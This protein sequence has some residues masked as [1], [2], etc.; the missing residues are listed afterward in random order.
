MKKP[1]LVVVIVLSAVLLVAASIMGT[2]AFLASSTAVSNTFTVG[3]VGIEMRESAVGTDGKDSDGADRTSDGNSYEL[4]P[5]K[6]YDKD[7]AIFV[8]AGSTPSYLFVKVKNGIS[9]IEATGN[10]MRDQMIAKGW[11]PVKHNVSTGEDLFLYV[12]E[13][14]ATSDVKTGAVSY[15]AVGSASEETY[16]IFD[17]FTV[18]VDAAVADYAGA[19]V[20]LTAFAI[21]IEGF[22]EAADGLEGYQRAWNA[23]VGRFPFE[24][25]TLYSA[26]P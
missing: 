22:T 4:I 23:I 13:N 21:Q 20:T 12:G 26:Q 24:S 15:K 11:Q 9:T 10:T 5:G 7:P 16:E 6:T 18:A 1:I 14:N 25:G 8:K 17:Q 2:L 3:D 19:K